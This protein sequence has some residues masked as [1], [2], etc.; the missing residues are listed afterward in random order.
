MLEP[1]TLIY[2]ADNILRSY[3]LYKMRFTV[4]KDKKVIPDAFYAP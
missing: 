3:A 2:G 4:V 1:S